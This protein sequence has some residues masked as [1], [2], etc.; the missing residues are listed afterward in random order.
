MGKTSF[1][2]WLELPGKKDDGMGRFRQPPGAGSLPEEIRGDDGN[3][4]DES[5][6]HGSSWVTTAVCSHAAT[7]R[8]AGDEGNF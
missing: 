7:L 1:P 4:R 6:L 3:F 8:F 5:L 2:F